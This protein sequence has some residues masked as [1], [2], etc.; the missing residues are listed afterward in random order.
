MAS[1]PAFQR[2]ARV[3]KRGQNSL[4]LS[5]SLLSQSRC[6]VSFHRATR[7]AWAA[8]AMC[9]HRPSSINCG[10]IFFSVAPVISDSVPAGAVQSLW[11]KTTSEGGH[12]RVATATVQHLR[13]PPC[14]R[15]KHATR[16]EQGTTDTRH[17]QAKLTVPCTHARRQQKHLPTHL[18]QDPR[19]HPICRPPVHQAP[20]RC[21]PE[22]PT[23]RCHASRAPLSHQ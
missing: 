4:F 14:V 6:S 11:R 7:C 23:N 8:C 9:A 12:P 22:R 1:T 5:V 13:A 21:L 20:P 18:R 15:D 16:C 17:C 2:Q 3:K 19:G 10:N